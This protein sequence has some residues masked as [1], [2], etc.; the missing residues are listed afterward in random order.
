VVQYDFEKATPSG[1]E[2]T[3]FLNTPPTIL[4]NAVAKFQANHLRGVNKTMEY[5]SNLN[6]L[7]TF[8][9]QNTGPD[10]LFE[11]NYDHVGRAACELCSKEKVGSNHWTVLADT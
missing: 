7:P 2:R 3:G 9:H 8:T 1:F 6:W 10:V 5:A 11:A 4:L